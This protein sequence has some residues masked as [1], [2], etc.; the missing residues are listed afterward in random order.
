M[1]YQADSVDDDER[2][3]RPSTA[4]GFELDDVRMAV[5]GIRYGEVRLAIQDGIVIQIDRVEKRRLR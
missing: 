2:T 5:K 3:P 1:T 4:R